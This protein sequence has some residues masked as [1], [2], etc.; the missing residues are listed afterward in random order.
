M[1]GVNKELLKPADTKFATKFLLVSRVF[2][3][4]SNLERVVVDPEWTSRLKDQSQKVQQAGAKVKHNVQMSSLWNHA[5]DLVKIFTPIYLIFRLSDQGGPA[6]AVLDGKID[7]K[8]K[9][10][11]RRQTTHKRAR[12]LFLRYNSAE[13]PCS[14]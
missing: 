6:M 14:Q 9:K 13:N 8:K 4:F 7:G 5:K 3:V 1:D 11:T 12:Y 10:A 2:D